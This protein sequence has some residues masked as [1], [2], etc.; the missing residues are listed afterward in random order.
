MNFK[1]EDA[2]ETIENYLSKIEELSHLKV[3]A[4]G[5]LLT[6]TSKDEQGNVYS[7]IRLRRRSVHIWGLE[8]PVKRGWESTFMEGTHLELMQLVL[9]KFSWALAPR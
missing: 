3:G 7:H 6:I 5:A 4:R 8:M 1:A 9:E 2:K